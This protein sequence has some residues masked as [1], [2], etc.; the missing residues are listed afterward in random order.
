MNHWSVKVY[1]FDRA[2]PDHW[3]FS[4]LDAPTVMD[5]LKLVESEVKDKSVLKVIIHKEA[6]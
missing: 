4:L 5:C 6:P 3:I 2:H 1:Y